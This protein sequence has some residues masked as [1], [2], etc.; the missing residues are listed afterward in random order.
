[1]T[2]LRSNRQ[3]TFKKACSESGSNKGNRSK[4]KHAQ[5]AEW[6]GKYKSTQL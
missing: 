6:F 5:G 4:E 3:F 1:M 2:Y